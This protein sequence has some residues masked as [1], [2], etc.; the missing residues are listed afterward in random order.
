[1]L[2]AFRKVNSGCSLSGVRSQSSVTAVHGIVPGFFHS[3][4]D[5]GLALSRDLAYLEKE[6]ESW[7]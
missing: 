2:E 5:V 1:M 3:L 6:E 7:S 4:A